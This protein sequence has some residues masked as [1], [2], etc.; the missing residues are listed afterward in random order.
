MPKSPPEHS[1]DGLANDKLKRIFPRRW[2]YQQLRDIDSGREYA[3]DLVIELI[4]ERDNR[5]TGTQFIVQNKVAKVEK[6]YV[7]TRLE[8]DTIE[9]LYNLPLP[10]LLHVYHIETDTSYWTWL[11]EW[12]V[13]EWNPLWQSQKTVTVNISKDQILNA[14]AVVMIKEYVEQHHK[15]ATAYDKARIVSQADPDFKLN[16]MSDEGKFI[17]QAKHENARRPKIVPEDAEARKV[18]IEGWET[19]EAVQFSGSVEIGGPLGAFIQETV[20]QRGIVGLSMSSPNTDILTEITFRGQNEASLFETGA[21]RLKC[22]RSGAKVTVI[23][24]ELNKY[25]ATFRFTFDTR[26]NKVEINCTVIPNQND[27]GMILEQLNIIESLKNVETIVITNLENR[28]RPLTI[29]GKPLATTHFQIPYD[30]SDYRLIKALATINSELGVHILLP[31]KYTEGMLTTTEGIA[32]GLLMGKSSHLLNLSHPDILTV[33]AV[34][35]NPQEM[36]AA[37]YQGG[38]AHAVVPGPHEVELFGHTLELGPTQHVFENLVMVNM[39]EVRNKL[40]SADA[41][42]SVEITYKLKID[43]QHSY[44]DFLDWHHEIETASKSEI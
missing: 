19:G 37:L 3:K 9:Y 25:S 11:K 35:Q 21:I 10:V 7:K 44:T 13:R 26:S 34:L 27:P 5:V 23:Q 14:T 29:N 20:G 39:D 28:E 22:I 8:V 17:I 16:F 31:D 42:S 32:E 24:C 36:L 12:Y 33:E 43:P 41:E 18:L 15:V 2:L 4:D 1:F 6:K 38:T 40:E 30:E